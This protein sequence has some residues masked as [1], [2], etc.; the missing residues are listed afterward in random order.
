M[1]R[2]TTIFS[3]RCS[4]RSRVGSRRYVS[5]AGASM[6]EALFIYDRLLRARMPLLKL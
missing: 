5:I 2:N 3:R 6:P 1:K 4:K